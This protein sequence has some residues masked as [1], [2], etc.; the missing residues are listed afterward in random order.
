MRSTYATTLL[1][2]TNFILVSAASPEFWP[3][4]TSSVDD[5]LDELQVL[6]TSG[7]LTAKNRAIIKSIVEPEFNVGN[8]AKA[9]RIAEQLVFACPE[10][11]TTG[12]TRNLNELRQISG[13][14]EA[15]IA[16]YKAVVVLFMTGGAD[17]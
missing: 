1:P 6:L 4:S 5:I 8:V 2:I 13:Y 12:S 7:R 17:R 16:P 14:T 15:P 11:H 9:V 3:A 10:F